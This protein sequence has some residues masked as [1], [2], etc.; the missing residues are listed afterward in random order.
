MKIDDEFE[1]EIVKNVQL[2]SEYHKTLAKVRESQS[3]KEDNEYK[4]QE[5]K[6]LKR[7]VKDLK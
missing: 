7:K 2:K 1:E 6:L 3:V 4:A 5:I